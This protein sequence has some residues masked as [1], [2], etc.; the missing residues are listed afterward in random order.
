MERPD[1]DQ[2]RVGDNVE[3]IAIGRSS[4]RGS[5]LVYGCMRICGDGSSSDLKKGRRAIRAALDNGFTQFDHADIYGGG[6]C[7]TLFGEFL[8]AHP[9]VRDDI[10]LIDKCGIRPAGSPDADSPKR[11]DFSTSYITRTVNESLQR[12][13]TGKIDVLL[14]HR[15]DY[16]MRADEVAAAFDELA[17]SG[18]VGHFGVSNFSPS[19]VEMLQSA[20]DTPLVVNQVELNLHTIDRLHDGTLD[21][22]QR[23]DMTPQAW[24]PLGGIAYAAW[25]N[26]FSAE[27]ELRLRTEVTRQARGYG[28]SDA[29]L[30]LAWILAH[31]ATIAP[32]IGSTTPSR[33]GES[34]ATP[35]IPYSREDWYRLLEARNGAPVP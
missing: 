32:I 9:S 3:S 20:I 5:R 24:C 1:P 13:G 7:E 6:M 10:V 8:R 18:K 28:C 15:P 16:L 17:R 11:Y 2:G 34:S 27:R 31:P 30:V 14:L 21:Q 35:D 4:L 12:L 25:G 29:Q 23:L 33:I 19:Q 22:C 26:T